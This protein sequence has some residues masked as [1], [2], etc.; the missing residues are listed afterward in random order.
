MLPT[1]PQPCHTAGMAAPHLALSEKCL[2]VLWLMLQ[3]KVTGL[4]GCL[5]MVQF[6]LRG[7]Q[8]VETFHLHVQQLS[9]FIWGEF[10]CKDPRGGLQ[11]E[12]SA[13]SPH[14]QQQQ[15]VPFELELMTLRAMS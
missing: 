13:G 4:Q 5:I 2:D 1:P 12:G 3:N 15:Q 9:L 11:Q 10:N 8:I 7:C 14:S 6:K